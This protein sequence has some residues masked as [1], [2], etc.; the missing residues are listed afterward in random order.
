[1][2]CPNC[3]CEYIRGVTQCADC[4]VPL[5][6]PLEPSTAPSPDGTSLVAIWTGDDP[7]ECAAAKEALTKAEIPF[8]DQSSDAYIIL[9]SMRPKTEIFVPV[10]EEERA[11]K[12]LIDLPGSMDLDQLTPEEIASLA[13]PE[14]QGVD[15]DETEADPA[16]PAEDWDDQENVREVWTGE[17]EDLA[18]NLSMSLREN[19]ISA[20]MSVEGGMRHLVVHPEKEARAR[21]IVREVVE[22]SPPE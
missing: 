9:R 21:K 4:G 17:S 6:D 14:S 7:A 12:A 8:V 18:N 16:E 11:R 3:K 15:P 10:A 13:L 20:H 5:V 1:M 19:G 22:A 2:I